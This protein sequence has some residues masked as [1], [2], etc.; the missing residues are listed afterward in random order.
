MS[1]N[2]Q[3]K[4]EKCEHGVNGK[5]CFNCRFKEKHKMKIEMFNGHHYVRLK[6]AEKAI[7]E[8]KSEVEKE[9]K[10]IL[11]VL[12]GIDAAD[13]ELGNSTGGTKAIRLALKSRI[14]K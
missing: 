13:R 3:E 9:R 8:A 10:F 7:K 14:I 1:N 4:R 11:N 12:D 5:H 6:H 2:T